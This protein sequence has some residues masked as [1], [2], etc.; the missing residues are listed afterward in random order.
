MFPKVKGI[1][2]MD[3]DNHIAY[4]GMPVGHAYSKEARDL[5]F[6]VLKRYLR[7]IQ[8]NDVVVI[9]ENTY[10]QTSRLLED[11]ALIYQAVTSSKQGVHVLGERFYEFQEGDDTLATVQQMAFSAAMEND[12]RNI[13]VLGGVSVYKAFERV[14]DELVICRF[15]GQSEGTHKRLE[16][17]SKLKPFHRVVHIDTPTYSAYTCHVTS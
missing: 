10:G 14:Y 13:H 15:H 7:D 17:S 9:G 2:A 6:R 8:E 16:F 4:N 3:S 1:V 12:S 11:N 5:D